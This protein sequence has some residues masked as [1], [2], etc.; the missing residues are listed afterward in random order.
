MMYAGSC[1]CQ[2]VKISF[3]TSLSADTAPVRA[4]ACR[5]C[6]SHGARVVTDPGGQLIISYNED[7]VQSYRFGLKT[8]DFLICKTCGLYI[9]AVADTP[10]GRRATLNINLLDNASSFSEASDAVNY[11]GESADERLQRR[12]RNWTPVVINAISNRT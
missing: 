5:F 10:R 6:R 12:G 8:A 1:H 3:E 9:A 4:C 7:A 11:D 2:A